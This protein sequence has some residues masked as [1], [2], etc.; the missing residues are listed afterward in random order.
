MQTTKK[1]SYPLDIVYKIIM[2]T[3]RYALF[4]IHTAYNL[5]ESYLL[6]SIFLFLSG[7]DAAAWFHRSREEA[8]N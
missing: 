8:N 6:I 2:Q 5:K 4:K 3:D 7:T 1:L